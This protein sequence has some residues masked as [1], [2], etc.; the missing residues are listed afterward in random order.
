MQRRQ[1]AKQANEQGEASASLGYYALWT[2]NIKNRTF[3]SI[4]DIMRN[5]PPLGPRGGCLLGT[6]LGEP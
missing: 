2:H 6:A 1:R 5:T 3:M 4:F